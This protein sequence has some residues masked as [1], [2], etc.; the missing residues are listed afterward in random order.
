MGQACLL[1][2]CGRDRAVIAVRQWAITTLGL[3]FTGHV[4][5]QPGPTRRCEFGSL[6]W[7]HAAG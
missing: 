2:W 4:L 7:L 6:R 3:H 1:V 5:I